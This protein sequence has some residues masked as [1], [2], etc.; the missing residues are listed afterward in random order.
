MFMNKLYFLL[1]LSILI[2][3]LNIT[4]NNCHDGKEISYGVQQFTTENSSLISSNTSSLTSE[5]STINNIP[6]GKIISPN[7][8]ECVAFVPLI[9]YGTASDD[10]GIEHISLMLDETLI[11][12]IGTTSWFST[13]SSLNLGFHSIQ[14]MV[15][16]YEGSISIPD[17]ISFTYSGIIPTLIISSP[18]NNQTYDLSSS[19]V[20]CSGFYIDNPCC[21]DRTIQ[22]K[23]DSNNWNSA[24]YNSGAVAGIWSN[25]PLSASSMGCGNHIISFRIIDDCNLTSSITTRTVDVINCIKKIEKYI[26]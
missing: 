23:I 11:S 20:R 19:S 10:K 6:I 22:Y 21:Y 5:S 9:I 8:N 1:F 7:P 12:S 16:D 4:I 14:L 17:V 26:E 2:V 25:V 18:S 3:I 15:Y 24:S 13:I